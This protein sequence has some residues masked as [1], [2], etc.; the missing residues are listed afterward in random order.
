MPAKRVDIVQCKLVKECPSIH[1]GPRVIGSPDDA[2]SLVKSLLLDADREMMVLVCLDRK[3]QPTHMQTVFIGTLQ[4]AAP[5]IKEK[6]TRLP[7]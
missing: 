5:Y 4:A 1:Y 2:Y 3:G 7:F 6:Y